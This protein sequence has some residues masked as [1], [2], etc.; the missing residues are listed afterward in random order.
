MNLS[1]T[2][3]GEGRSPRSSV[4]GVRVV[5]V[6]AAACL[7]AASCESPTDATEPEPTVAAAGSPSVEPFN[8]RD[9]F[10]E[11]AGREL[12]LSNCQSCH[13]LV[14]I[15]VLAMDEAAWRRNAVEHRERVEGLSDEDFDT[16]YAYLTTTFTPERPVPE[17]PAA[18]LDTWTTY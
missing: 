7:A 15:L 14:P 4:S 1:A 5:A 3:L 13:V 18:L 6:V 8:I 2:V 17:L 11:G 16:L 12:V 9:V 10:P